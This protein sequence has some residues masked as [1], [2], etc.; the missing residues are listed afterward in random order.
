MSVYTSLLENNTALFHG[1]L[2]YKHAWLS[3]E[4]CSQNSKVQIEEIRLEPLGKNTLDLCIEYTHCEEATVAA[5][6]DSY[7]LRIPVDE[8][9][10]HSPSRFA[11]CMNEVLHDIN[12][13]VRVL[14]PLVQTLRGMM[15]VKNIYLNYDK[16]KVSLC[17]M[18]TKGRRCIFNWDLPQLVNE[19]LQNGMKSDLI[20]MAIQEAT[21]GPS[22]KN[23]RA[24][25]QK[26][27]PPPVRK[28]RL[29]RY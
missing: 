22:H 19:Y 24:M 12:A 14:L 27:P 6:A 29:R 10:V 21:I 20:K 5:A 3:A 17:I 13:N 7:F 4:L 15:G 8:G 2:S 11:E 16:E 1:G 23:Y 26:S 18:R 9:V 25:R 28:R